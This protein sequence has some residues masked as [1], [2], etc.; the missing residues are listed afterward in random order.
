MIARTD[1]YKTTNLTLLIKD[2]PQDWFNAICEAQSF[3]QQF[4]F[5]VKFECLKTKFTRY[6]L[7][8]TV[9][10][11]GY[12]LTEA[13]LNNQVNWKG[14]SSKLCDLV[15]LNI[16]SQQLNV[17]LQIMLFSNLQQ[18]TD[19]GVNYSTGTIKRKAI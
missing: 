4:W 13:R 3:Y 12:G 17:P 15:L 18:L 1:P 7:A 14:R 8:K 5:N 9:T 19:S 16:V 11:R 6:R 2:K 10:Q